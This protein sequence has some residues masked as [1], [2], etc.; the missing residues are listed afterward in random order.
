MTEF[1]PLVYTL[2]NNALATSS[3][4]TYRSGTNH[5]R[6]FVSTF[7]KLESV[8]VQFP[9][10]SEHILTLCFFAAKLSLKKSIKSNKT[11]TSYIRHVKNSWIQ[12]GVDPE[13]LNSD[14]LKRVLKGLKRRLPSKMDTRPAFLLPHYELPKDL[15]HPTSGRLCATIAAVIFGFF[16]SSS[17]SCLKKTG[18][19]SVMP[20]RQGGP[21]I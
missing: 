20:G 19:K 5:F 9:P 4:K 15:G 8:S 13:S 2:Y 3:K 12:N 14:V 17:F 6:K 21:S 1:V 7:P 10:P 16:W 18:T 11:I